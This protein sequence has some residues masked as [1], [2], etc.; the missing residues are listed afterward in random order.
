LHGHHLFG[1]GIEASSVLFSL[2]KQLIPDKA[3]IFFFNR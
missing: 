3:G 1:H 2:K